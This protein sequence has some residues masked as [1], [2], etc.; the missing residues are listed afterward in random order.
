MKA[1][2]SDK[3][4][5]ATGTLWVQY[6]VEENFSFKPGQYMFINLI[7]PP[8]SD[9]KGTTRHFSIVSSPNQKGV[10]E[11]ATRLR[12]SAFKKSL[13]EMALGTEVE[14]QRIAGTFT[15]PDNLE[16]PLVFIAG[17]IGITPFMSMLKF[18]AEEKLPVKITLL[19]SNRDKN[20]TAFFADLE[21]L[22]SQ[23]PNLK[24]VMTM[25]QDPTWQ[26]EKRRID[27][28]FIKEYFPEVNENTYYVVGPTPMVDA[29][30]KALQE[31]GVTPENIKIE[32]FSG[33]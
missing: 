15:L 27:S 33:Y 18:I 23:I 4:E 12:D 11:M 5:I 1:R 16:K 28:Q 20:S 2:L 21:A 19:Y 13:K 17:G 22:Q 24:L 6:K 29:V 9:E 25:T 14:I 31:A 32:N 3:K 30:E 10:L 26:G 7:K 8:Y